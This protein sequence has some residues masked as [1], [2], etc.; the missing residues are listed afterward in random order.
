MGKGNDKDKGT[1]TW[2]GRRITAAR[3]FRGW[4]TSD[5]AHGS[6]LSVRRIERCEATGDLTCHELERIAA[7]LRLPIAHFLSRCTLCHAGTRHPPLHTTPARRS[8]RPRGA[9][10]DRDEQ[11][12]S[13]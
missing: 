6:S 1:A 7:A 2:I 8:L 11:T 4:E 5:L 9:R 3:R 10:A 13:R 12:I